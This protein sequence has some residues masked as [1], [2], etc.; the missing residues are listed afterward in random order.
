MASKAEIFNGIRELRSRRHG[1]TSRIVNERHWRRYCDGNNAIPSDYID[2]ILELYPDATREMVICDS[3]AD[4]ERE[5][6]AWE[7]RHKRWEAAALLMSKH[8]A[9]LA[10]IAMRYYRDLP[11][12]EGFP[13]L[14]RSEWIAASPIP[15]DVTSVADFDLGQPLPSVQRLDGLNMDYVELKGRMS[16]RRP[17]DGDSYRLVKADLSHGQAEFSFAATSY[18]AYVNGLDV[19]G[20]ELA[21]WVLR[22]G[23]IEACRAD[24]ALVPKSRDL[25]RRGTPSAAFAIAERPSFAGVNCLLVVRNYLVHN[26]DK[27]RDVIF[28]H[29]RGDETLEAQNTTHVVPAGG[30]Q[31]YTEGF[32][33]PEESNIFRTVVRE[34]L[35]ELFRKEEAMNLRRHGGDLLN[36]PEVVKHVNAFFRSGAAQVRLLGLGLDPLTLKPELLVAIVVDWNRVISRE[37][38]IELKIEANY[39]GKALPWDLGQRSRL[40]A[41]LAQPPGGKPWLPAGAAAVQLALRHYDALLGESR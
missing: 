25:P 16:P 36:H 41:I 11:R 28:C 2:D 31:P 21:D 40:A 12:V 26:G 8:R 14:A 4:F 1:K 10:E 22:E 23:G 5:V 32:G 30:H 9:D 29:V 3:F 6:E 39:E 27:P 35:E 19:L 17:T 18:F 34:F 7:K 24:P 38:A 37:G 20:V 15:L 33:S 13:L